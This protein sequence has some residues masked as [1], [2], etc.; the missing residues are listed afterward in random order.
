VLYVLNK[1]LYIVFLNC[2]FLTKLFSLYCCVTPLV[3]ISTMLTR[4]ACLNK[5]FTYL[6][7]CQNCKEMGHF[8]KS[9]RSQSKDSGNVRHVDQEKS[10]DY[11]Q[12][13]IG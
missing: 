7:T 1:L 10:S 11:L 9:C 12:D 2:N 13:S 5:V 3:E 8:A 6:P 4:L